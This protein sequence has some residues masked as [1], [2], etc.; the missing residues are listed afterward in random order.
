MLQ[1]VFLVLSLGKLVVHWILFYYTCI[2]TYIPTQVHTYIHTI[3]L[4][5]GHLLSRSTNLSMLHY[6][7]VMVL[8]IVFNR[9]ERGKGKI[10][11]MNVYTRK[12]P[13]KSCERLRAAASADFQTDC[14]ALTW[15]SCRKSKRKQ[16]CRWFLLTLSWVR[17]SGFQTR[18][19][20]G[21]SVW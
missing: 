10:I 17:I 18:L 21:C 7:S 12:H 5:F 3:K 1:T 9:L 6:N 13:W 14:M 16:D 15:E 2:H 8:F 4:S 19:G 20:S 11:S